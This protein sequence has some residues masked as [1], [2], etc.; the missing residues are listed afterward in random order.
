MM[1]SMPST[2]L[3]GDTPPSVESNSGQLVELELGDHVSGEVA[4]QDELRLA[5]HRLLVGGIAVDQILVGF[6][7]QEDVVA[8]FDDDARFRLISWA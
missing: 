8:Q 6:R 3:T 4:R 7:A 1:P 5:G 2:V